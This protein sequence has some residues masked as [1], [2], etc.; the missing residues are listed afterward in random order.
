MTRTSGADDDRR[1]SGTGRVT[2]G[3]KR[4]RGMAYRAVLLVCEWLRTDSA[5]VP[6]V[7]RVAPDNVHFHKVPKDAGFVEI[8]VLGSPRRRPFGS[9]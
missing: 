9:L 6:A 8:G 1:R 2:R 4:G 7:I 5:Y 3:R